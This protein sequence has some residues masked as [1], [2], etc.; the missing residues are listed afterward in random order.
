MKVTRNEIDS[1]ALG[2][3]VLDVGDFAAGDDLAA[4]E[5]QYVAEHRPGYVACK[6]PVED[7]AAVHALEAA[8]FQFVEFQLR[9]SCTLGKS[10]DVSRFGTY[11]FERVTT[12]EALAPVLEIAATAFTDDRFS[13]D[14]RVPAGVSGDRYR[15]YVEKSFSTPGEYVYRLVLG[16][17]GET[18]AFKTHRVV[19]AHDALA[20]LGGVRAQYQRTPVPVVNEYYEFNL[21]REAGVRRVTT[22]VSGRNYGVLN[23]EVK[24][25][26]F[27]VEAGFVVLR[28]WYD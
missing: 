25:L 15:R 21:L 2:R 10:F 19:G 13:A 14:P 18:A 11:R 27:R 5:R 16:D 4:A 3:T 12:P 6:V 20:L 24:G 26:G 23:L 8:G 9:T 22:H 1:L 28:K 7:L 17:T